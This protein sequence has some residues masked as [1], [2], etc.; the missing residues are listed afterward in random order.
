[1]TLNSGVTDDQ[2]GR[3]ARRV[4]A[5][6]DRLGKSLPYEKVMDV[7]QQ[8]HD[9]KFGE[10]AAEVA[11]AEAATGLLEIVSTIVIPATTEQFVAK[12]KF[13]AGIG[14]EAEVKIS[15]IWGNFTEWFLSPESK[16]EEPMIE[17]TLQCHRLQRSTGDSAI[18]AELGGE[19]K[20][21][22]MLID[23]Y[24]LMRKWTIGEDDSLFSDSSVRI[25]YVRD[26]QDLLRAVG[27]RRSS[28][29]LGIHASA[30]GILG[31]WGRGRR[32]FSHGS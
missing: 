32:V 10:L 5:I 23:V 16:V 9:G 15:H 18:I 22:T 25:F 1:M 20:S 4:A 11:I 29:G 30:I 6:A 21:E 28:T 3:Y 27:V 14:P 19:E 31:G 2:L 13:V 17:H 7:L 26:T 12:D 24:Y 8:I